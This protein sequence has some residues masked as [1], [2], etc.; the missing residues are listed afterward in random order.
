[1]ALLNSRQLRFPLSG[2]FTGSFSGSFVGN[3]AGITGIVSSSFATTASFALNA[4]E[5][6]FNTGSFVTTSSFNEYTSSINSRTGSFATT[7]S[8]NALSSSYN[9]FTGSINTFTAS[10]FSYTSSLS[11]KTASFATTSSLN[12]LSSSYNSYTSSLNAFSASINS[13]T[14]SL[15]AKTASFATTGSNSFNGNQTITGSLTV[16][17]SIIA[18]TLIVQTITSSIVFSSGSNKFGNNLNNTQQFTGSVT[19]TG[20]LAVNGSN[21]ILSNQT[22][23]MSVLSASYANNADLLDGKDSTEFATTG[24]N[25]F[26]GNQTITGSLIQGLGNIATGEN[27]HAEGEITQAIGLFSHAEGLGTIAYGGRSHAEG[28]DTIASGSYSHAEGYQTI[29]LA[30]HQHVQGQFNATSSVP[31]AFIVGNGT[32]DSNRSNLIH[33]AGNEVQISGNQRISGSIY[34]AN[35]SSIYTNNAYDIYIKPNVSGAATLL[36]QDE[37]HYVLVNNN[38]TF[39]NDLTVNGFLKTTDFRGT[40]SL[41]GTASFAATASNILGGNANHIPYFKTSTTLASSSL[42]QSGA[43]SVIIN[44]DNATSAN[45]EALYVWQPSTSINVI[46]GKGNLNNY[47]QLNIQNVNQGISASS[48]VV[49]T[50]NNGN[51]SSNYIDMGIN[52]Q[53]YASGFV[54][55]ANDAYLYSTGNH[56]HIGN[57][58]DFPVQL[59]AGGSDSATNTKL[60]L[61]PNNQHE[62]TGSLAISGSINVFNGITGSLFGNATSANTSS[63]VPAAIITASAV[64]TTLTFTRFNGSTFNVTLGQSGSVASA[65]YAVNSTSASYALTASFALN[66]GGTVFNTGSFVTT[67]SFNAYTSSINSRTGSFATTSSLNALSSSYN[68]FTSSIFSFTSSLNSYTSSLNAKT[69]SFATTGSNSFTGSE[70]ISGSLTVTGSVNFTGNT[71]TTLLS[72]NA[73]TL[74]F[75]QHLML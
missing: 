18:Q 19:I 5:I 44:Q 25:E 50:A 55:D 49:A 41:Q 53:N 38:G 30:D 73:D 59:F 7:S 22:S 70:I 47:L 42:Y 45:P 65:S 20:S 2:S 11:A 40:G 16:S 35:S 62:L 14:Q 8:L 57:V 28:Q 61:Y 37:S 39:A 27:S 64:D 6:N 21:V 10:I 3:G 52:S 33:A 69:S 36:S 68:S 56:L 17:G 9:S 23:S 54:G 71:G 63:Y 32:D 31:A 60:S 4:G 58:S 66:A 75:T 74:I 15:S 34:F 26:N 48:D 51:E 12:A 29:A 24:S 72:T 46:S 1:M 67:S 13:Y 43:F